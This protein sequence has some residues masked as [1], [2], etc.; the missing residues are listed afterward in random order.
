[1]S[2]VHHAGSLH[3]AVAH[4]IQHALDF[5]LLGIGIDA[6]HV[7]RERHTPSEQGTHGIRFPC[8]LGERN[9]DRLGLVCLH[10]RGQLRQLAYL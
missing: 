8:K 6:R 5:G 10:G 3:T 9:V 4:D 1:M 2:D 7:H